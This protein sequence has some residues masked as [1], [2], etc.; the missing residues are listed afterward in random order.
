MSKGKT[1]QDLEASIEKAIA[2]DPLTLR[3][4]VRRYSKEYTILINGK[5]YCVVNLEYT[6]Q[7]KDVLDLIKK[8]H[9][10]DC[11][12]SGITELKDGVRYFTITCSSP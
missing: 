1:P 11:N 9:T 4:E 7:P 5:P 12:V 6:L 3:V 10:A 8:K 2:K